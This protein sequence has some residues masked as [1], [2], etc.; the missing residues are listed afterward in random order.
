MSIDYEAA[1]HVAR[2]T[3]NRPEAM[4]AIDSAH[5]AAL[6]DAWRQ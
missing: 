2:I 1:G 4:N 3:I 5:N 6:E